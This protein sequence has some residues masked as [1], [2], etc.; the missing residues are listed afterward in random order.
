MNLDGI[1]KR[2]SAGVGALLVV[3]AVAALAT[4]SAFAFTIGTDQPNSA[5]NNLPANATGTLSTLSL[6]PASAVTL[7]TQYTFASY[8]PASVAA[9]VAFT[10]GPTNLRVM[11]QQYR[12]DQQ[13]DWFYVYAINSGG[14][15]A[16]GVPTWDYYYYVPGRGATR[17]AAS[18]AN[19]TAIASGAMSA[20]TI[21][22][23]SGTAVPAFNVDS[24]TATTSTSCGV[25][26]NSACTGNSLA[27]TLRW[28]LGMQGFRTGSMTLSQAVETFS[29]TTPSLGTPAVYYDSWESP[30]STLNNVS[31]GGTNPTQSASGVTNAS[32]SRQAN[33]A[34]AYQMVQTVG[35]VNGDLQSQQLIFVATS[36]DQMGQ[37][38]TVGTTGGATNQGMGTTVGTSG[39]S[40]TQRSTAFYQSWNESLTSFPLGQQVTTNYLTSVVVN[41]CA[42]SAS[43]SLTCTES[44]VDSANSQATGTVSNQ[45][46][47]SVIYSS[48]ARGGWNVFGSAGDWHGRSSGN[49]LVGTQTI[50]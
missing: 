2:L 9:G 29:V 37:W 6:R 28:G 48:L 40:P 46:Q 23:T 50:S 15:G 16:N 47:Y 10:S 35:D 26:V 42:S 17:I 33:L 13:N 49:V 12:H 7:T 30:T 21:Y 39:V 24:V 14:A 22:L 44:A 45:V 36:G 1:R 41:N 32:G 38:F 5:N 34:V 3:G 20:S 27:A 18:G 8:V 4:T 11:Y 43:S 19:G 25:A 31:L